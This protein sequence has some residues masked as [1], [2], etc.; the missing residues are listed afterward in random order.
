MTDVVKTCILPSVKVPVA[1]NCSE[2]LPLERE[3]ETE[4]GATV[5]DTN[6]AL[7]IVKVA[8]FEVIPEKPAVMV[9]VPSATGVATPFVPDVLLIVATPVSDESQ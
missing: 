9:V 5:M 8:L 2:L 4:A 6:A 3:I 1:L 7:A